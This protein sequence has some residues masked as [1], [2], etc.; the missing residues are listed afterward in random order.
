VTQ[1]DGGRGLHLA[2]EVDISTVG[3][4]ERALVHA[5]TLAEDSEIILE[6][7][8]VDFVDVAGARALVQAASRLTGDQRLVLRQ[9]PRVLLLVLGF[10][11]DSCGRIEVLPR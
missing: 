9:P 7:H 3:L 4:L 2:G 10:F 1:L 8:A 5:V 11:P 6:M